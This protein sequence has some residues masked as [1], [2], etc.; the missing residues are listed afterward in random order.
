[1]GLGQA[2][3]VK[4]QSHRWR[5]LPM[6]AAS[7]TDEQL[8]SLQQL[9]AHLEHRVDTARVELRLPLPSRLRR[10]QQLPHRYIHGPHPLMTRL[11]RGHHEAVTV[12][13]E[14][15]VRAAVNEEGRQVAADHNR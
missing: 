5:S 2:V 6:S 3:T 7:S 13:A 8:F 14:A 12:G 10:R 15:R 11:R 4:G 1:M 9:V